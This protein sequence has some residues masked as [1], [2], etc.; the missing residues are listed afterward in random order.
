MQLYNNK[1]FDKAQVI[2]EQV[3]KSEPVN[4]TALSYLCSIKI[5]KGEFSTAQK[6]MSSMNEQTK[7]SKVYWKWKGLIEEGLG[8]SVEAIAA[9]KKAITI[10]PKFS[11]PYILLLPLLDQREDYTTACKFLF[12]AIRHLGLMPDFEQKLKKYQ[13]YFAGLG[14][15][16]A[17]ALIT[18][19]KNQGSITALFKKLE[20]IEEIQNLD[21][22][23]P[24]LT[25]LNLGGNKIRK[26]TGLEKLTEL[27]VLYLDSNKIQKI[28]GLEQLTN[29]QNI[30]LAH[31]AIPTI[32]GLENLKKLTSANFNNNE[33][34]TI[35]GLDQLSSLRNLS[36]NDNKLDSLDGIESLVTLRQLYLKGNSLHNIKE[37]AS[38]PEL[39]IL[40]LSNN[41]LTTM[42]GLEKN[43]KI[44][45]LLLDNNNL[46]TVNNL[47]KLPQLKKLDLRNNP[48]LPSSLA[49]VFDKQNS[50][51]FIK[52]FNNLS[53]EEIIEKVAE[54]EEERKLRIK[55]QLARESFDN[56]FY[57]IPAGII[58]IK[59]RELLERN[60]KDTCLYCS[61]T[62]PLNT[63]W[64]DYCSEQ[65]K[66]VLLEANKALPKNLRSTITWD[67]EEKEQTTRY[68]MEGPSG[69]KTWQASGLTSPI[70]IKNI[71]KEK[72]SRKIFTQN[73]YTTP[74]GTICKQ[75]ADEFIRN[76]ATVFKSVSSTKSIKQHEKMHKTIKEEY[77]EVFATLVIKALAK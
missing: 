58:R 3:L 38:L 68:K 54:I 39:F 77:Y 71:R 12:Q 25:S 73:D 28:E 60:T 7:K 75:C 70:A 13:Q 2:F 29:L 49:Q 21:V 63:N 32:E 17:P 66:L 48:N 55:Q 61:Q 22:T 24:I 57:A 37:L 42:E 72:H 26:I 9:Y 33:I 11:H 47:D 41:N 10:D 51:T 18:I 50:L 46:N 8:N 6:I 59:Y 4:Q 1:E 34:T 16:Q 53:P 64:V 44:V 31:N 74:L 43:T 65:V 52:K 36:L 20:S 67:T 40:H 35:Q 14:G 30:I 23:S 15:I 5:D 76:V 19:S 27:R 45:D 69:Q 62:M 56:K